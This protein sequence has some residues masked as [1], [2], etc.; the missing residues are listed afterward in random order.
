MSH[1]RP[2]SSGRVEAGSIVGFYKL[3]LFYFYEIE[4]T[5]A[6]RSVSKAVAAMDFSALQVVGFI[7]IDSRVVVVKVE[8]DG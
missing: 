8:R 3:F 6:G 7:D 2:S 4:W 1:A 5:E